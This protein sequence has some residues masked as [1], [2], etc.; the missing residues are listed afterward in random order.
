LLATNYI[1]AFSVT[2]GFSVEEA[3]TARQ[4]TIM[5]EGISAADEQ[6]I[7]DSGS[8]VERLSGNAYDIEAQLS[9]RIRDGRATGG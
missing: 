8:E 4:V 1:L 2:V 6:A 5:G 3:K 7:R 9:G